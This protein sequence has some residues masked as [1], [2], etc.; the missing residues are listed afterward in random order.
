MFPDDAT[1]RRDIFRR[2][3]T[4]K[5]GDWLSRLIQKGHT[6]NTSMTSNQGHVAYELRFRPLFDAVRGCSFPCDASGHVDIDS[7]SDR[8][9][10]NYFFARTVIG[11]EFAIPAV[12]ASDLH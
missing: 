7:L 1:H 10:M 2:R 9:R 8:S 3:L 5:S 6:V 12:H 4:L 11:R